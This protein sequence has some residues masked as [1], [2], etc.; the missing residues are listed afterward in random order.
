MGRSH[1]VAVSYLSPSWLA[2]GRPV[3]I[4]AIEI[5]ATRRR[6]RTRRLLLSRS[7]LLA[8]FCWGNQSGTEKP[9]T[10]S[11]HN[12]PSIHQH[13]LL[14]VLTSHCNRKQSRSCS[15]W[16]HLKT[17]LIYD[18]GFKKMNKK[19]NR[20][21]VGVTVLRV[22]EVMYVSVLEKALRGS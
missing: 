22:T 4:K 17:C 18:L 1:A 5:R 20:P 11:R 15:N 14:W 8:E 19:K 16:A 9:I 21:A 7:G 10:S 12:R 2:T 3:T 6:M 13:A